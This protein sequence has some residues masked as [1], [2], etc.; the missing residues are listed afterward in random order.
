MLSSVAL[1]VVVRKLEQIFVKSG[2]FIALECVRIALYGQPFC[3]QIIPTVHSVR[4]QLLSKI[5]YS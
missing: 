4:V 2:H 1:T 3:F 5:V